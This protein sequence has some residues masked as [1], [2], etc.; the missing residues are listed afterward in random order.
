VGGAH[1]PVGNM[2]LKAKFWQDD[3]RANQAAN[4]PF[5][6][7]RFKPRNDDD[8]GAVSLLQFALIKIQAASPRLAPKDLPTNSRFKGGPWGRFFL[9]NTDENARFGFKVGTYDIPTELSVFKFQEQA[10]LEADGHAGM[11]TLL[12]L[13][14]VLLA[15]EGLPPSGPPSPF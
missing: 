10:G 2:R 8:A 7:L 14:K 11:N 9:D 1:F 3:S 15:V 5:H 12:R 6:S 4:V 13:D